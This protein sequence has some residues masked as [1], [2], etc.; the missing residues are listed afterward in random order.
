MEEIEL[1][2][3]NEYEP[4]VQNYTW[5]WLFRMFLYLPFDNICLF[6]GNQ[7][8]KTTGVIVNYIFRMMGW[9][10]IPHR[11]V[12]YFECPNLVKE[13]RKADRNDDDTLITHPYVTI[14]LQNGTELNIHREGIYYDSAMYP[15][16]FPKRLK[17]S[18]RPKDNKC[19]HCGEPLRIHKRKSR[20]FRFASEVLP[21]ESDTIGSDDTMAAE[22]NNASYPELKKWLP[23][24]LIKKDIVAR[25]PRMVIFD[26]NRGYNFDGLVYD[27]GDIVVEFV[28][29]HQTVQ[30]TAGVQ[31][32]SC[33]CDE[34]PPSDWYEEQ[35]PRLVAEDGDF[36][37]ALT[38]ANRVTYMY[39]LFFEKAELYL[40]TKTISDFIKKAFG[41]KVNSDRI[42]A[43]DSGT[44]IAVLQAATDDNPTL[45]KS[46]IEKKYYYDD[47]DTLST[48]RYGIFRQTVG[49]IF[50]DFSYKVHVVDFN[51]LFKN[52]VIPSYAVDSR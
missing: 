41:D 43:T 44:N 10:P 23:P 11:N 31:R 49:R 42:E 20:I 40:R 13:I 12:L 21:G 48:R 45:S 38:P 3:I 34:E 7:F 25:K 51:D 36:I 29:Y 22:I 2:R 18:V 26:P 46:A 8:G 39:D 30:R 28:A 35:P 47:E 6:T 37:V 14:T 32:L 52:G 1:K 33:F 27:D 24:H 9:H 4:L 17:K 19:T 5:T 50:N 15:A 16:N